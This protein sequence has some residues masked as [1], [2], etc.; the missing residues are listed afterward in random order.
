MDFLTEKAKNI[1]K[2]IDLGI[3]VP[4]TVFYNYECF[5]KTAYIDH[6]DVKKKK[7]IL[8]SSFLGEDS[9]KPL[10][11]IFPTVGPVDELNYSFFKKQFLE[12]CN[13]IQRSLREDNF[14]IIVQEYISCDYSGLIHVEKKKGR[15]LFLKNQGC[16]NKLVQGEGKFSQENI[17]TMD[18]LG[19]REPGLFNEINK[20][21]EKFTGPF[22]VEWGEKNSQTYIFQVRPVQKSEILDDSCI[23]LPYGFLYKDFSFFERF[24][25]DIIYGRNGPFMK[26]TKKLI[27]N[28]SYNKIKEVSY[29]DEIF[30][31]DYNFS[32]FKTIIFVLRIPSF[33]AM[34]RD[35]FAEYSFNHDML[36]DEYIKNIRELAGI[37]I[38]INY[39]I[40]ILSH[41]KEEGFDIFPQRIRF[42]DFPFDET[43]YRKIKPKNKEIVKGVKEDIKRLNLI[44][45]DREFIFSAKNIVA[46]MLNLL[47]ISF[48]ERYGQE[49]NLKKDERMTLSFREIKSKKSDFYLGF[50][51][52]KKSISGKPQTE[53]LVQ[54]EFDYTC[55]P[56]GSKIKAIIVKRSHPLS[57]PYVLCSAYGILFVYNVSNF[58]KLKNNLGKTQEIKIKNLGKGQVRIIPYHSVEKKT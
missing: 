30:L 9:R 15:V 31:Q 40:N 6:F 23:D 8:R 22:L 51:N 36:K 11:G 49:I 54:D 14:E 18:E 1:K 48:Y 29:F 4:E 24:L 21:K 17:I 38:K 44:K 53:I 5:E 13:R 56:F 19:Q 45:S 32:F 12:E 47:I 55:F 3:C 26:I 39:Y 58:E 34:I 33:T 20:I 27:G 42:N 25:I 43:I 41:L 16:L 50:R 52:I 7:L 2:L 28:K 35:R 46:D 10:A 57:H 37:S